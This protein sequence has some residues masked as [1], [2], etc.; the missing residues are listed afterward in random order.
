MVLP[1]SPSSCRG[2]GKLEL[3]G[4]GIK[5]ASRNV[6]A[7]GAAS[8][9]VIP[10]AKAKKKLKETGKVNVSVKVTFV[11]NWRRREHED[12]PGQ[13]VERPA[14]RPSRSSHR[15]LPQRLPL[16]SRSGNLRAKPIFHAVNLALVASSSFLVSEIRAPRRSLFLGSPE[17]P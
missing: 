16:H 7:A 12:N 15:V 10:P 3:S 14:R 1:P 2:P 6:S 9:N 13:T 8:L 5:S 4:K 17:R 11:P